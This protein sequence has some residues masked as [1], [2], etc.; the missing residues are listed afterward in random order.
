MGR[1]RL[2]QVRVRG[3]AGSRKVSRQYCECWWDL[4]QPHT[5]SYGTPS[6]ETANQ[7]GE[8]R[9]SWWNDERRT[10]KRYCGLK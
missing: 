6:K 5:V 9:A 2:L 7:I 4:E 10:W 8:F 3:R 1:Q